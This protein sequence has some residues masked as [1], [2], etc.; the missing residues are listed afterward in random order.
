MNVLGA[1]RHLPSLPEPRRLRRRAL[2]LRQRRP[3]PPRRGRRVPRD[4][5]DEAEL[6]HRRRSGLHH[7][8]LA[9][10]HRLLRRPLH[11]PNIFS[12]AAP[13][14]GYPN[15]AQWTE[16]REP[17]HTPWEDIL[18]QKRSIVRYCENGLHL[19]LH[20]I[21]GGQ[22]GPNRS[23]LIADRY[24]ALGY[25]RVFDVQDG[26]TTNVWEYGYEK[27][28]LADWLRAHKRPRAPR[29]VR[30][31]SGEARYDRAFW[32][33]LLEAKSLE[34]FSLLDAEAGSEVK[35]SSQ[36]VASFAL[37]V[38]GLRRE[39]P[40]RRRG[41]AP[42]LRRPRHELRHHQG[43]RTPLFHDGAQPGREEARRRGR[44]PGRHPAPPGPGDLRDGRSGERR[45]EQAGG[46]AAPQPRSHL[47][48]LPVEI[49]RRGERRGARALVG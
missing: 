25:A 45:G 43:R 34:S 37:D 33:T 6:P 8:L 46:R 49:R 29:H 24:A 27:G 40:P 35:V 48:Q 28:K 36:N 44:P 30:L 31:A 12:A 7:R 23:A 39:D 10:R 32:L 38:V 20:I 9:R 42:R 13:L 22:D 11:Y 17:P 21:H 1:A 18:V 3:A 41:Q 15:L 47:P 5:G 16:V 4:R 26:S 19:P 2:G 14:C